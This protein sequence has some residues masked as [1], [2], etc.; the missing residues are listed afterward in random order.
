MRII[1]AFCLFVFL[2]GCN[3]E[4]KLQPVADYYKLWSRPGTMELEVKKTLMECGW[5]SPDPSGSGLDVAHMTRNDKALADLCMKKAGFSYR[6]P[7]GY[8]GSFCKLD[9]TLPACQPGAEIPKPSKEKRMNTRYC[10]DYWD[11][12]YCMKYAPY[13]EGC[14]NNDP[15]NIPDECF[16]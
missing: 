5:P 6:D 10:K 8:N 12:E 4:S 2:T 3:I 9:P 15:R 11:Y 1:L 14:A 16:P 7:F 13:P